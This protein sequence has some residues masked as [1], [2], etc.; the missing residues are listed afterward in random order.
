MKLSM[1]NRKMHYWATTFIAVPILLILC[2]GVLLQ[3]KKHWTWVQP[4]E[5]RG[6]GTSPRIHFDDILTSV[7]GV[8]DLGVTGWDDIKRVDV[9]PGRGMAKVWLQ[10]GWEIQVD[11]GT[12]RVLQA[13][14]R[15]SDVIE[16]IHD[17][18]YFAGDVGKFG[19]F[20]PCG[21]TLLLMWMTGLW[22]FWLP[23]AAKRKRKKELSDQPMQGTALGR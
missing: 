8:T 21:V 15:R 4:V 2:S 6:T 3:V 5:L 9:R 1:L 11:L 20:L 10:S 7:R 18:S 17:G 19:I 23:F 13:A 12:A 14:Y 22:M 16:S